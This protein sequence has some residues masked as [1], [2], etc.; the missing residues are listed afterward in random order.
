MKP[1]D[2]VHLNTDL[3][4]VRE[5]NP[6]TAAQ[7]D[8]VLGVVSYDASSFPTKNNAAIEYT[9]DDFVKVLVKGFIWVQAGSDVAYNDIVTYDDSDQEW[10]T[11]T[12]A[13]S[14][15]IADGVNKKN[16]VATSTGS[17]GG[18]L[19]VYVDMVPNK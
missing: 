2:G 16:I 11:R 13:V 5:D 4:W 7:G 3:K 6:A 19:E 17:D 15:T 14:A 10:D 12:A 18:L 9:T 1:G 8:A